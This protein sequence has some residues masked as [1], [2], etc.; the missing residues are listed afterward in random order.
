MHIRFLV[1]VLSAVVSSAGFAS[2]STDSRPTSGWSSVYIAELGATPQRQIFSLRVEVAPKTDLPAE[3]D[4][5]CTV[6]SPAEY[7]SIALTMDIGQE[8]GEAMYQGGLKLDVVEGEQE[9]IL[10][11]PA[12]ADLADGVY[13][14]R[15]S[16]I[17]QS[18]THMA[19]T[20]LRVL[21]L[22]EGLVAESLS[23]A[24]E[25]VSALETHVSAVG[26]EAFTPSVSHRLAIARET[27]QSAQAAWRESNWPAVYDAAL[28][29]LDAEAEVRAGLTFAAL[30]PERLTPGPSVVS[31]EVSI[32]G[33]AVESG[34]TPVFLFGVRLSIA[35]TEHVAQLARYGI[36]AIVV[37]LSPADVVLD[38]D[39][40]LNLPDALGPVLDECAELGI[41][42]ALQ[43]QPHKMAGWAL[44]RWPD[45]A[46]TQF[47]PFHYDVTHPR[48]LDV[49]AKFYGTVGEYADQE[50]RIVA[51]SVADAPR[52]RIA[53]EP[54]RKGFAERLRQHYP[55]VV[56]LNLAWQTRLRSLD[57][58][59]IRWDWDKPGY[60][61]HL[62]RYHRDQVT[63]FFSWIVNALGRN[64]RRVPITFT[65]PGSTFAIGSAKDG[66]DIELINGTFAA[67]ACESASGGPPSGY[68]LPFPDSQMQHG[69][70]RSLNASKPLFDFGAGSGGGGAQP[71]SGARFP[72][73]ERARL[74]HSA[75]AGV[76]MSVTPIQAL[77]DLGGE[78]LRPHD[79]RD[80]TGFISGGQSLNRLA[81][82]VQR[83]QHQSAPIAILWSDSSRML[84]NGAPYLPSLRRAYEGVASFGLPVRF[85]SERQ[86]AAGDLDAVTVLVLP[87]V[88]ALA[89]DAFDVLDR[90]V[91]GGGRLV[92]TGSS[93]PYDAFGASR[94][95]RLQVSPLTKLVRGRENAGNYMRALDAAVEAS[96]LEEVPRA[97]DDRGY[98]TLGIISRHLAD[99]AGGYLYIVNLRLDTRTVHLPG[100]RAE[101][102]DLID[103]RLV[104]FPLELEPLDPMLIALT[105]RDTDD[106]EVEPDA[107]SSAGTPTAIVEPVPEAES[108][109]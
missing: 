37:D 19:S 104:Q 72:Y 20:R 33:G 8:G 53:D 84:D 90:Y 7:G 68:L 46:R 105:P 29:A 54:M 106:A 12:E 59:P 9:A 34:G 85:V 62:Q 94:S 57:E 89:D 10:R 98:P 43:L 79:T 4:F 18:G 55:S 75:M 101:G 82:I 11:W 2:D 56:E 52:F 41:A 14:V 60:Q 40:A 86:I 32:R 42:V 108:G 71:L 25:A 36:N 51:V 93:I 95:T 80:L 49:L 74:W 3:I 31:R 78:R 48:A 76:D 38:A 27:V 81:D 22:S 28:E 83:F 26:E 64:A 69:L 50:P 17:R 65:A 16:A 100:G 13:D 97:V 103:G 63:G 24:T 102:R 91:A 99:E 39:S 35:Q 77:F 61:A 88:L 87:E 96:D 15:I 109:R 6:L 23:R 45:M 30:V 1:C 58:I 73:M 66:I 107:P 21:K 70:N 47:A 67:G 92:T 5:R 44:D